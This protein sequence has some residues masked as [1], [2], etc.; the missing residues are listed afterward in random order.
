MKLTDS[1]FTSHVCNDPDKEGD[2]LG[3]NLDTDLTT[4]GKNEIVQGLK[5]LV[6]MIKKIK[7]LK[8]QAEQ[9]HNVG[10]WYLN[11]WEKILGDSKK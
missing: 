11:E 7:G 4:E 5:L 6:L 3:W 10:K 2:G 8:K 9:H 1:D